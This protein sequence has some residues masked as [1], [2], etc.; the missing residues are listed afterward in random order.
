M[1][2]MTDIW[3]F[4]DVNILAGLSI[5]LISSSQ[6]QQETTPGCLEVPVL[7]CTENHESYF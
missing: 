7:E 5:F 2:M 3:L 6:A 1:M 4:E